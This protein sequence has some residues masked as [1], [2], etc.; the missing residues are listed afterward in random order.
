MKYILT[1]IFLIGSNFQAQAQSLPKLQAPTYTPIRVPVY[2]PV[3]VPRVNRA[4]ATRSAYRSYSQRP[5]TYNGAGWGNYNAWLFYFVAISAGNS[6]ARPIHGQLSEI[7]CSDMLKR[8][9][10]DKKITREEGK[11]LAE[12][13]KVTG[14]RIGQCK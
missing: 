13:Q 11:V 8:V 14:K 6:A 2:R 9:K 3:V 12:W 5:Y 10:E 4:N 7:P 1:A